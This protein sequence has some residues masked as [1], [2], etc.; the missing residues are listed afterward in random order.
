MTLTNPQTNSVV[1]LKKG[2]KPTNTKQITFYAASQ[3]EV[4]PMEQKIEQ[5]DNEN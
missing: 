4:V 5:N 1:A 3:T 2:Q